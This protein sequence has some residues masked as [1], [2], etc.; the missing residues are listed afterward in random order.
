MKEFWGKYVKVI[1]GSNFLLL[2]GR[3][4]QLYL[5]RLWHRCFPVNFVKFLIAP[6]LTKHLWWLFLYLYA[7]NQ[8]K[9]ANIFK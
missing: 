7:K 2:M 4:L 5:K 9:F 8:K 6:F 1:Y 3:D